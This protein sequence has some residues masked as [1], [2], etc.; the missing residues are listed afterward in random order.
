MYCPKCKE[1]IKPGSEKRIMSQGGL[2]AICVGS[3]GFIWNIWREAH[4][5]VILIP[6]VIFIGGGLWWGQMNLR[7]V[8]PAC[9][10]PLLPENPFDDS[11]P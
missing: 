9:D 11:E 6:A 8:C 4:L 1:D 10:K 3:V 2:I 7:T 5:L